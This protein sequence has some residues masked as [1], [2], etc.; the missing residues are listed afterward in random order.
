MRDLVII[1]A[2]PG[3]LT[4]G[5]YAVRANLDTV[6]LERSAPGGK[7]INTYE[8]ENWPGVGKVTGFELSQQMYD[9]TQSLGVEYAYG[10]VVAIKDHKTH[11]TVHTEDGN[12]I[13]TKA[14]I[15][16]S[17][18]EPRTLDVPN[19]QKFMAKGI[20]FCAVCDGNFF[21]NKHV[22]VLGGGNSAIEES[23]FLTSLNVTVTVVNILD[24]LQ[25]DP[26]AINQ[27][28]NTGMIDFKLGYEVLSF[29][30][31]KALSGVRVK[32]LKTGA[33]S[34]LPADGA[35]LFIGHIPKTDFASELGITDKHGYID[36]NARMETKTPGIYGIGDVI[37]K[38]LRQ[39]VTASADGA[40]A[41]QNCAKYIE[42]IKQKKR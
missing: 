17:G 36:V 22:V 25:A 32:E 9:H 38:E 24:T 35:F 10:N 6:M 40:I 7:M 23:V 39:I 19:E 16:A 12:V 34:V 8:I 20:S 5:I 31:D 3:G 30:G 13:E 28:K 14:I 37:V 41:A 26:K 4:A 21:K 2:G 33:I 1:G 11:K 27:A 18:T 29:E 15:I 42:S